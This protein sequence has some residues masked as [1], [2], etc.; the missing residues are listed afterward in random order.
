MSIEVKNLTKTYGTQ[1]AIN[2]ISFAASPGEIIGLLGP[3]GAGKTTTMKIL[4]CFAPP[5]DGQAFVCGMEV[6]K[7]DQAI[8]QKIGYL[9]EHN[10]LYPSMY[11]KEYLGFVASIHKLSDKKNRISAVIDQVGLGLEQKKRIAELSKGYRQR[12]GLAQALLH[13]PDVLILDEP[14]SGLDPNQLLEIRN[15]IEGLKKD[16]TIIFSSHILQEVESLCDKVVILDRGNIVADESLGSLKQ[17]QTGKRKLLLELK[18]D[19]VPAELEI[20]NGI[21]KVEKHS[22]RKYII[23]CNS[24]IDIRDRLF[25]QVV[26]LDNK[27]YAMTYEDQSLESVFKELTN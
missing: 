6:G 12:V 14:I 23:E 4:T 13:D 17:S 24:E 10:P 21:L 1:N 9:P 16:K 5:T 2:N 15:L 22:S 26:S 25:D 3:N 19:I 7:D 8:K 20:I 18:K 11:V 27:I